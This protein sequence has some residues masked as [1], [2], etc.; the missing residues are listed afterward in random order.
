MSICRHFTSDFGPEL[1][2]ILTPAGF[3]RVVFEKAY[4]MGPLLGKG[5]FGTV[6]AGERTKDGIPVAI[7]VIKKS[8]ITQWCH[9]DD[10]IV[11]LEIC[12][13]RKVFDVPGVVRLLDFYEMPDAYVLILERPVGCK[14]LFDF[15]NDHG[16]L[17]ESLARDFLR[18][19]VDA[20]LACHQRGVI[21]RDIKDENLLVTWSAA[22][23]STTPRVQLLD[24]GSGAHIRNHIYFEFDGTRVYAPPEWIQCNHYN[25]NQATVWSLGILLYAM[26]CGNIPFETDEQICSAKLRFRRKL[27]KECQDLIAQCLRIEAT[28]RILLEDVLRHPWMRQEMTS[29]LPMGCSIPPQCPNG[30]GSSGSS[31]E[32]GL[33]SNSNQ[34]KPSLNS[35][36][37][38][39][40]TSTDECTNES[41][42]HIIS[43][44]SRTSSLKL[45]LRPPNSA[46]QTLP[47]PHQHHWPMLVSGEGAGKNQM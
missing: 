30:T 41:P 36:G 47:S 27:S 15:I 34:H 25:G 23:T 38:C 12:L 9:G 7:K 14:D 43:T 22:T 6:Y 10:K 17:E 18:Q 33:G 2:P 46:P 44:A 24:F 35:V 21:H 40:S 16:F 19:V 4:K 13:L 26:V 37:S 39:I 29:E 32:V 5:G 3:Q 11:P 28:Q 1:E 20:I 31:S 45:R 8:K 42:Q